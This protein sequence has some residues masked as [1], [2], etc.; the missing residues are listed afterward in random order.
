[1]QEF[2]VVYL[3]PGAFGFL[4][5]ASHAVGHRLRLIHINWLD[6]YLRAGLGISIASAGWVSRGY[7]NQRAVT[8]QG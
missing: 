4:M 5:P 6:Y 1:M 8:S 7:T 2:G 3:L